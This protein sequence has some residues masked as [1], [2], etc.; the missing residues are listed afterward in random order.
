MPTLALTVRLPERYHE[1]LIAELSDLGFTAFEE[2]TEA[3]TAYGPAERWDDVGR[4]QVEGWLYGHGLP[5]ELSEEVAPEENWNARW[6]A[7]IEPLPVGRFLIKPTWHPVPP[8]HAD[9]V[10]LEIDPKMA[11]GTGYHPSTR[12]ALRF[13]PGIVQ[14]GARVLD[15]GTGTGVLALAALKLGADHAIGFD[16]DPWASVNAAENAER[17]GLAERFEVR[18]GSLEVVPERGFDL[19]LA[20][21]NRNT[22][23]DMLP[24]LAEWTVPGGYIVL[25]GLL[26][27]DRRAVLAA[28]EAAGLSLYDEASEA[29]WWSAVVTS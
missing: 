17:N 3:I 7:S 20:N 21:I 25:A 6:E 18:E 8:E 9:K 26:R 11:F 13:L 29:E 28:A 22:L 19:V 12:M 4:Q 5:I 15:A 1:F 16:I 10:I 27:E 24:V 14:E 2:G 23:I